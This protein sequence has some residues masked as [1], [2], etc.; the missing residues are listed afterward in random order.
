[1]WQI[2]TPTST[3]CK[4]VNSGNVSDQSLL[5]AHWIYLASAP[6]THWRIP[7]HWS[8]LE[9]CLNSYAVCTVVSRIFHCVDVVDLWVILLQQAPVFASIPKNENEP[10]SELHGWKET[11]TGKVSG[12]QQDFPLC[13]RNGLLSG[14]ASASPAIRILMSTQKWAARL[15]RDM[16]WQFVRRSAGFSFVLT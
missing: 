5:N 1:M 3:A 12:G 13:W 6:L 2:Q 8:R 9:L 11:C 7:G 10:K 16:H 15:K 4:T 14:T